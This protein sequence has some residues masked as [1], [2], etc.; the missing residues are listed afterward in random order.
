VT[1]IPRPV[2]ADPFA[3]YRVQGADGLLRLFNDA[4]VLAAADIQIARRLAALAH[5]EDALVILA[6]AFAVRAPRMGHVYVSLAALRDTVAV[7]AEEPLDM[8]ALPW[9]E[10]AAWVRRLLESP[11]VAVGDDETADGEDG[12]ARPLRLLGSSLYLDRYWREERQ[13]AADLAALRDGRPAE[14]H[15]ARLDDGLGRLFG[16]EAESSQRRA[17]WAAVTHRLTVV[18]GGPGTGKT[19]TIGRIAAL[20]AEQAEPQRPLLA[21]A[22]PTGKAAARLQEAIRDCAGEVAGDSSLRAWMGEL[23]ASTLHRLLGWRPARHSRFR[24]GR[25]RRLPHDVVIVDEASMISLTLMARLTE[26][27]RPDARLVLVGDPDQLTS[28]EAG[29]VL[30]DIVG[31]GAAEYDGIA[32]LDRVYR[33]GPGIAEV[34][35]AVRRGDADAAVEALSRGPEG[36]IWIPVDPA[37]ADPAGILAPVRDRAVAAGRAIVASAR[38]GDAD[39]ALVALEAFRV[40]CAHRRGPHGVARWLREVESW[41]SGDLDAAEG[42]FYVGRPLLVIENDYDLRLFNGDTGVVIA[43]HDGSREA[44]FDRGA[45]LA[46]S[47]SRLGAVDTAYAMTIHKSQ[48][49]QFEAAAVLLPPPSSR[50]LTRELLYTAI[51]R[52]RRELVVVGEEASIRAAIQRPAARAT[53]LS[54]RLWDGVPEAGETDGLSA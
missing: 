26:A 20:L 25:G 7:D 41:L 5:D 3:A 6:A 17:A 45:A 54:R 51:T 34:A 40:L 8:D 24:H 11:L 50:I 15:L 44:V 19:A 36:V 43:R 46:V 38:A 28:I 23:E 10:S 42:R 30:G 2:R 48:G 35:V 37:D 4:G 47:P 49:S 33:F 31:S 1:R 53:G 18:A 9:P 21:L 13:V 16:E 39:D 22:A 27:L 32:V 12:Q 52:A 14:V 29:A